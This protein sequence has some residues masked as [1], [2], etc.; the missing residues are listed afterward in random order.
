MGITKKTLAVAGLVGMSLIVLGTVWFFWPVKQENIVQEMEVKGNSNTVE[1]NQ[2][3]KISLIHIENMKAEHHKVNIV[4]W[5]LFA[6]ILVVLAAY[7]AHYR[8]VRVPR[9]IE[10]RFEEDRKTEKLDEV[11]TYCWECFGFFRNKLFILV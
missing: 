9:N 8:I 2:A 11:D 1:I 6:G 4:N 3:N 7:G 5:T 10:W